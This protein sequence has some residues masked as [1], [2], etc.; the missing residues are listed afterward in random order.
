MA[1]MVWQYD[2]R[3]V[4]RLADQHATIRRD[5]AHQLGLGLL[6][7][8][9]N[10]RRCLLRVVAADDSKAATPEAGAAESCA[11]N[12]RGLKEDLVELYHLFAPCNSEVTI[13]FWRELARQKQ[14]RPET[15]IYD[16][17]CFD[18]HTAFIVEYGA[19]TRRRDQLPKFF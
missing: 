18:R 3:G 19:T 4:S 5:L 16:L 2:V 11:K 13:A 7:L 15:V 10:V 12:A 6:V 14:L 8:A 9:S 17:K 1:M